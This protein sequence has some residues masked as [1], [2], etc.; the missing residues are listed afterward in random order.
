MKH[1]LT[2]S[3]NDRQLISSFLRLDNEENYNSKLIVLKQYLEKIPNS[4][5][6]CDA[7]IPIKSVRK[8]NR[9]DP[10]EETPED[11]LL[12]GSYKRVVP[13]GFDPWYGKPIPL[14]FFRGL[15]I[16]SLAGPTIGGPDKLYYIIKP[17]NYDFLDCIEIDSMIFLLIDISNPK[18]VCKSSLTSKLRG[19]PTPI[20]KDGKIVP[21]MTDGEYTLKYKKYLRKK[22]YKD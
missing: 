7:L 11:H 2:L 17:F 6:F 4:E 3:E 8:W 15:S 1:Q 21:M 9:Y 18:Y 10:I 22:L 20:L 19:F 5:L 14:L 13:A 12:H 16:L